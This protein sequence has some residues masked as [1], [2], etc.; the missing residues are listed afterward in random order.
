MN[1]SHGNRWA[2]VVFAGAVLYV[3][4]LGFAAADDLLG[5]GVL[6]PLLAR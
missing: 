2:G 6:A 1:G 4:I 5:W 3:L